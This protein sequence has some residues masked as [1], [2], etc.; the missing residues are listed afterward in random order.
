MSLIS[1]PP[2]I[3]TEKLETYFPS[4][5]PFSKV[6]PQRY[7]LCRLKDFI[8]PQHCFMFTTSLTIGLHR[9]FSYPI[10]MSKLWGRGVYNWRE[11]FYIVP[12]SSFLEAIDSVSSLCTV[13][14]LRWTRQFQ[15]LLTRCKRDIETVQ[16]NWDV[17]QKIQNE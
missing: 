4:S 14:R 5:H 11:G 7:L 16:A 6:C 2:T 8:P 13:A 9:A 12:S 3:Q 15:P 17:M 10:D 1:V